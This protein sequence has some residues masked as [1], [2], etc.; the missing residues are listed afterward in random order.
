M[1]SILAISFAYYLYNNLHYIYNN[2]FPALGELAFTIFMILLTLAILYGLGG[3]FKD[4]KETEVFN[5]HY[6]IFL[7]AVVLLFIAAIVESIVLS[8]SSTL[9]NIYKLS[10][11]YG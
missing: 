9:S 1:L 10:S 4:E 11:M 5:Y 8:S 6:K 2:F 3:I 7:L